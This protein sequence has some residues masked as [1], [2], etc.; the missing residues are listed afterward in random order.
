MDFSGKIYSLIIIFT[1]CPM[2]ALAALYLFIG[3]CKY[4]TGGNG[5]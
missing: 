2:L 4:V 1:I 3:L 5:D